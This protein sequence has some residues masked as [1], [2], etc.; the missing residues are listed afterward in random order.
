MKLKELQAGRGGGRQQ[1]PSVISQHFSIFRMSVRTRD[2]SFLL[3][4]EFLAL[5]FIKIIFEQPFG[6][7]IVKAS[8]LN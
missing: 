5:L 8:R 7:Q 4:S 2:N 1:K 3:P 6:N